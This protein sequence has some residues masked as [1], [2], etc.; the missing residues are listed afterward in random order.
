MSN[1]ATCGWCGDTFHRPH[2][3]GPIPKYCSTAHRQQAYRARQLGRFVEQH[4]EIEPSPELESAARRFIGSAAFAKVAEAN[5]LAT[6]GIMSSSF[7]KVAQANRMTQKLA[8]SP[9]FAKMAE[10]NRMTQKL[11]SSPAFAKM[12]EAN[13]LATEGIMSSS[14]F[15]KVAEANRLATQVAEA[16]RLATQGIISSSAFA[17]VAEASVKSLRKS[18]I[19]AAFKEMTPADLTF[20]IER[21]V[22]L[23]DVS[24]LAGRLAPE[25]FSALYD[26]VM[27]VPE[28][29]EALSEVRELSVFNDLADE[30]TST[31]DLRDLASGIV[32]APTDT[33]GRGPRGARRDPIAV[34]VLAVLV[35]YLLAAIH[36]E[37]ER[38]AAEVV[39]LVWAGA[40]DL[41]ELVAGM[42]EASPALRGWLI[43]L[44][45][46][47]LVPRRV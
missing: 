19:W 38:D 30:V 24:G 33:A 3:R 37:L 4:L 42:E 39:R 23:P 5:R 15:A 1:V 40:I 46:A 8:S 45:L 13:R 36:K 27:D 22:A 47:A 41:G 17:K 25:D 44:T 28:A 12:A 11:A 43:L 26:T 14:A 34:T 31:S 35:V 9:A 16:N 2:E 10:A 18:D 7:A 6:Q 32:P 21:F 20:S 29:V